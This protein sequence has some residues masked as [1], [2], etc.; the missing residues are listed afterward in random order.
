MA[1]PNLPVDIEKDA[2][3]YIQLI[4]SSVRSFSWKDITVTVK[5]RQTKQ[6]KELLHDINGV[7]KAGK[8]GPSTLASTT[9]N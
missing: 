1:L 9:T 7:V 4:N 5:D 8:Q 6:P 2:G 3:G